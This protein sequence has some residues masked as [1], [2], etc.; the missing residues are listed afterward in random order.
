MPKS[1]FKLCL[2]LKNEVLFFR[3]LPEIEFQNFN[4][5]LSTESLFTFSMF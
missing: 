2:A 3:I 1:T 4:A 5:F